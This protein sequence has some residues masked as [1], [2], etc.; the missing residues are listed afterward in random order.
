MLIHAALVLLI[1]HD[2]LNPP[3][4]FT[5]VNL[6]IPVDG[7]FPHFFFLQCCSEPSLAQSQA[8]MQRCGH[9]ASTTVILCLP[10][11]FPGSPISPPHIQATLSGLHLFAPTVWPGPCFHNPCF[12]ICQLDF[13][14]GNSSKIRLLFLPSSFRRERIGKSPTL[15]STK[16]EGHAIPGP[17][18]SWPLPD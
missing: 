2:D 1:I 13:T 7:C 17:A 9:F 5:P 12:G 4:S 15:S 16:P 14:L 8:Q 10:H 11:P 18:L 6:F 3:P